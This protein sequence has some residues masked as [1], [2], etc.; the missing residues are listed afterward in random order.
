MDLVKKYF[1]V[2]TRANDVMGLVIS[3][4]LYLIVIVALSLV[5]KLIGGIAVI[6]WLYGIIAWV[7]G[8][9]C[10]VG[11]VLAVLVFLKLLK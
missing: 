6:G 1:P 11:I 7:I 3:I 4:V 8:A 10:T 2:S 9:Y 5:G